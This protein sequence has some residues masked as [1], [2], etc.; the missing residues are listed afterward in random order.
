MTAFKAVR[1]KTFICSVLY[2]VSRRRLEWISLCIKAMDKKT[3]SSV[4]V[5]IN[6][7]ILA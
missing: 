2:L 3:E 5:L 1:N 7:F 4:T 6:I